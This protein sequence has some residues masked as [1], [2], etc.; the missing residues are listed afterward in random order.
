MTAA[1]IYDMPQDRVKLGLGNIKMGEGDCVLGTSK[2]GG[3][4]GGAGLGL[5]N[6]KMWGGG[7]GRTGCRENQ[8]VGET[9]S[10]RNQDA[11]E[12]AQDRICLHSF[13]H[14]DKRQA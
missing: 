14:V 8:D 13:G 7:G 3:G 2:Y 6:M 12:A 5:G 1:C 4:G 11:G 9:G 10:R